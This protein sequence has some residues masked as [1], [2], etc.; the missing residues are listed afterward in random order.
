M[1]RPDIEDL[2]L[3]LIAAGWSN[4]EIV[5]VLMQTSRLSPFQL[6]SSVS[7]LAWRL[8][9]I[10]KLDRRRAGFLHA[11]YKSSSAKKV[12]EEYSDL[13]VKVRDMLVLEL[14]LTTEEVVSLL[15]SRLSS[16]GHIP[17]LSKKSLSNWLDRLST[18]ISPSQILHAAAVV[19]DQYK[20]SESLDWGVR[21]E[22]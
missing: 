4:K 16:H 20:N 22:T 1:K 8:E 9:N 10:R 6:D 15:T 3:M 12:E 2:L 11:S 7:E 18:F 19:R 17:P 21:G 13:Y 14:G 5:D